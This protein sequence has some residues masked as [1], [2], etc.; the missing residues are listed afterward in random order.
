MNMSFPHHHAAVIAHRG[1]SS[2]AIENSIRAFELA[3]ENPWGPCDA[4]ELDIHTT[5]DGDILVH[6]DSILASGRMISTSTAVEVR[7]ELLKDGSRIPTLA[8]VLAISG[9]LTVHIEVKGIQ[10]RF[11]E[12]LLSQIRGAPSPERCQIHGFD[13]RVVARIG[14]QAPE[15][16]TGVLSSSYP[17]DPIGPVLAAGARVL[18]QEADLID[19]ELVSRAGGAGISVIAWTVNDAKRAAELAGMGVAGLCGNWPE[20]LN[21]KRETRDEA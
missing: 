4:I 20:R 14:A 3:V 18:W 7:R 13:H 10:E 9:R 19:A 6:H 16:T 11:D 1:V 2:R 17:L 21:A 12:V 5:R 15:L 8:E